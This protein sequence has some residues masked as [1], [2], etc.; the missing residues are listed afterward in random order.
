M[1]ALFAASTVARANSCVATASGNWDNPSSWSSCGNTV[2]TAAD[3]VTI[4]SAFTINVTSPSQANNLTLNGSSGTRLAFD[5]GQVVVLVGTLNSDSTS[6]SATITSG[7]GVVIFV[8]FSRALF[9]SQW[10][11]TTTGLNFDVSLN[12]GSTGTASTSVKGAA[13]SISSGTFSL[14]ANDLRPDAGVINTGT[15]TIGTSGTLALSGLISRGSA[16]NT[17]FSSFTINGNGVLQTGSTN[18][19]VFPRTMTTTFSPTSIVDYNAGVGQTIQA[20]TYGNLKLSGSGTKIINTVG[21]VAIAVNGS[22]ERSG[23]ASY[24]RVA[25]TFSVATAGTTLIYSGSAAQTTGTEITNNFENLTVKSAAT[26]T[27]A[28][29]YTVRGTVALTGGT[30]AA[31]GNLVMGSGSTIRRGAGAMTGS[32]PGNG[33]YSVNYTGNSKTPGPELAGAGL[34]SLVLDMTT[35]QTVTLATT[36]TV[37]TITINSGTL[38]TGTTTLTHSGTITVASGAQL[39]QSGATAS[40]LLNGTLNNSGTVNINGTFQLNE[41]SVA[42]GTGTF[43]YGAAST[44]AFNNSTGPWSLGTPNYWP[45]TSGPFNVNVKGVGGITLGS[46]RTVNGIIQTVAPING[47][48]NLTVNGTFQLNNNIVITGSP[49]Y[50]SNSI[51]RYNF[52]NS[53]VRSRGDEWLAGVTSGPGYPNDVDVSGGTVLDLSSGATGFVQMGRNLVV[54]QQL[55]MSIGFP[56]MTQPFKVLGSVTINGTLTLS[57]DQGGDLE[58][59]GNWTNPSG[60]FN[61]NNRKVTFTG[62]GSYS[63]NAGVGNGH[64]FREVI[65]NKP[66]GALGSGPL[67]T[68]YLKIEAGTLSSSGQVIVTDMTI[69]PGTIFWLITGTAELYVYHSLTCFGTVNQNGGGAVYFV[70]NGVTGEIVGTPTFIH[71]TINRPNGQVVVPPGSSLSSNGVVQVQAGKLVATGHFDDLWISAPGTVEAS[72]PITLVGN[73]KNSGTFIPNNNRVTLDDLVYNEGFVYG[74]T[75]F[76][77]LTITGIA[78]PVKFEAGKTQTVTHSLTIAG[79]PANLIELRSLTPGTQWKL[80]APASQSIAYVSAQDSDAS[81]G[82]TVFAYNSTDLTG[83]TNWNFNSSTAAISGRVENASGRGVTN[84]KVKVTGGALPPAGITV[85]TGRT[86]EYIVLGLATNETYTVTVTQRRYSTMTPPSRTVTPTSSIINA[87]FVASP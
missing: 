42:G 66:G 41:G 29:V 13:I 77:D 19:D 86:G 69:Q 84:A 78:R 32:G 8:G 70:G 61:H 67:N 75:T 60:T 24:S 2:P 85:Y 56:T 1:I 39:D 63:L 80:V 52:T 37:A 3:D 72:G 33:P 46:P 26:V 36:L 55:S 7:A 44:L 27:L 21:T 48:G 74:N 15:L 22:L 34:S 28:S 51:L 68:T 53:A 16:A 71:V 79:T 76:Y 82:Q 9:G 12:A 4:G 31:T 6:P 57:N 83:N 62:G 65:V 11:P 73:W 14:G 38:N 35:G 50:G 49:T 5:S 40:I 20:A 23:T 47:A 58:V 87:D 81:G 43:T 10:G 45:A 17:P 18:A 54:N 25:G 64:L 30:L 59:G